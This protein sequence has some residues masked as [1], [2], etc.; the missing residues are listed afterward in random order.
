MRNFS[1]RNFSQSDKEMKKF[2]NYIGFDPIRFLLRRVRSLF[3]PQALHPLANGLSI[4]GFYLNCGIKTHQGV[5]LHI[6]ITWGQKVYNYQKFSVQ[7]H[8]TY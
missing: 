2:G 3:P 6:N 7:K 4:N 5:T 1:Q 8:L